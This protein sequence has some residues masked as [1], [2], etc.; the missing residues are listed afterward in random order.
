M[1][2]DKNLSNFE[3]IHT[4]DF[5]LLLVFEAVFIH[6]SVKKAAETLNTSGSAISQ[7][8]NKLRLHFSDPLFVRT[9]QKIEPTTVAIKL[10]TQIGLNFGNVIEAIINFSGQSTTQRVVVYASPYLALRMLP[11]LC[12]D[13]EKSGLPCE[14]VHLS[15]D[16]LMNNGEDIL[17]Y[18]KADI[19]LDTNPYYSA[20]V[21]SRRCMEE[22]VV[23]VCRS[24]HPRIDQVLT[25]ENMQDESATFL[26]VNTVGLKRVQRD[27]DANL[28]S[29]HFT[30]N[31]SSVFV[32]AAVSAKT[33]SLSFVPK[34]FADNYASAMGLKILQTDFNIDPVDFYINYNK[35][36][37]SNENFVNI[38]TKIEEHFILKMAE[39]DRN[40]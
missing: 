15:A 37:M 17:A 26:N 39:E 21:I 27:I 14:L 4:F 24:S 33:D 34:W 8:L 28:F 31:S 19:V 38:I 23:A 5:N 25:H 36:A 16:S 29:R 11:D 22:H 30:F 2:N 35:S 1:S 3:R 10:H 9:G 7:S 12:A 6:C 40:Q 32:N 20:S 13:I 18:R